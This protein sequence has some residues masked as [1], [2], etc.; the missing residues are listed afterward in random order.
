ML[1][2]LSLVTLAAAFYDD[3]VNV[4]QLSASNFDQVRVGTLTCVLVLRLRAIVCLTTQC[5]VCRAFRS[6]TTR[7]LGFSNSMRRG[8]VTAR[9]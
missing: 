6:L 8:A 2:A 3:A 1:F 4:V 5:R 7:R 9:I